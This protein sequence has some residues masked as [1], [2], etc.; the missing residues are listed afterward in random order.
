MNDSEIEEALERAARIPHAVP[1]ELLKRIADSIEPT[2]EPVRPLPPQWTLTAGLV[3][4]GVVVALA[5][6]ARAGFQGY[7]A[8]SLLSRLVIFGTLALLTLVTAA[9][10]VAAWIPGSRRR[11]AP[12]ALL[13]IVSVA[14]ASVF[15]LSFH[16]YRMDHFVS[17]GLRCLFT[18]LVCAVPAAVLAWWLL[19]R[20]W[21]VNSVAAGF[22]AGVLAGL[23]GVAMLELHCSNLQAAHVL[24][25]HV[26][27]VPISAVVGA[28]LG[29][30]LRNEFSGRRSPA[31]RR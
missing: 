9:E 25:W 1:A 22:L 30:A 29:W 10:V 23:V 12:A 18:G 13:V 24:V 20:G 27:V 16:D 26:L 21:V 14:L 6:A 3:L 7:A 17:A 31:A 11:L 2:L 5:G 28:V 8:L 4:S 15:A 19:R